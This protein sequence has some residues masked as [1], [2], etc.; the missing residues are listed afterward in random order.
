MMEEY[1]VSKETYDKLYS[2][3]IRVCHNINATYGHYLLLSRYNNLYLRNNKYIIYPIV[4]DKKPLGKF[5]APISFIIE[6]HIPGEYN[7]MFKYNLCE[8]S[9]LSCL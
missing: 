9:Y 1:E 2:K 3:K 6:K 5:F 4:A 7:N 8:T